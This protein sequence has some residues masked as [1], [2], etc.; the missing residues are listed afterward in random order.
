MTTPGPGPGGFPPHPRH[1]FGVPPRQPA[2]R[3]VP[4]WIL[5][6]VLAVGV[7]AGLLGGILGGALVLGTS[8]LE[9]LGDL[10]PITADGPLDDGER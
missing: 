6:I 4:A 3:G 10:P 9:R 5:P 7:A 1:A 8:G 2:S